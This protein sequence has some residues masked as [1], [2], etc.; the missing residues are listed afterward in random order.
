MY[1]ANSP[2]SAN[3]HE[4]AF[5]NR[6]LT[7][8]FDNQIPRG[9]QDE[10]LEDRLTEPEVLN[11]IFK[12][13]LDGMQRLQNQGEFT[14]ELGPLATKELFNLYDSGPKRFVHE[15]CD[16]KHKASE[17]DRKSKDWRISSAKLHEHYQE[18]VKDRPE[19]SMFG[20]QKFSR[21]VR[22]LPNVGKTRVT[23]EAGNRRKGFSGIRLKPGAVLSSMEDSGGAEGGE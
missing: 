10:D 11:G 2:P 12:W 7:L 18:W 5:Y 23:V 13:A 9:E 3:R 17:E 20:I 4:D 22:E 6:F 19:F 21:K 8:K 16:F 14:R 15:V 1:A